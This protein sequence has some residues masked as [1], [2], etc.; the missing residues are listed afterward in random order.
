MKHAPP[1]PSGFKS[2]D[3]K[4]SR[5]PLGCPG[6]LWNCTGWWF[7]TYPSIIATAVAIL[8]LGTKISTFRKSPINTSSH[9]WCATFLLANQSWVSSGSIGLHNKPTSSFSIKNLPLI[10]CM[11]YMAKDGRISLWLGGVAGQ[12][13]T[14]SNATDILLALVYP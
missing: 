8:P 10:N 14:S 4:S 6:W 5:L 13:K 2:V 9:P 7:L 3:Q 11:R 12:N 1:P